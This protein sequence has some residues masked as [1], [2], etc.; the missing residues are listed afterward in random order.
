M[1][2]LGEVLK[3]PLPVRGLPMRVATYTAIDTGTTRSASSSRAEV[4]DPANTAADWPVGVLVLDKNEKVVVNRG[5]VSTLAPA[6]KGLDSPRLLLTSVALDPGEYTLRIGA[7]DDTGRGGSVHHSINAR[8][9]KGPSGISVVGPDAGAAA[10][11]RRRTAA[12]ATDDGDRQRDGVGDD[13]DDRHRS[14]GCSAR[15]R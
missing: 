8:L 15:P 10:A 7:V 1:Q 11:D 12:A 9:N 4:G 3:S 5:G 14:S 2:Q 13:R 6:S